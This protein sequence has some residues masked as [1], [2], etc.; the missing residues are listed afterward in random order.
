MHYR[1]LDAYF[2]VASHGDPEAYKILYQE[3]VCKA[4]YVIKSTLRNSLNFPVIPEDFSEYIDY[5]FFKAINEY[6][7]ERGSFSWYV[8]YVV[9]L[10]LEKKVQK[11]I[12]ENQIDYDV[13]DLE[14]DSDLDAIEFLADPCQKTIVEDLAIADFKLKIASPREYHTR[15]D[16]LLNKI[17]LLQYAGYKNAEIARLLGMTINELRSYLKLIQNTKQ[18]VNLK[19]DLK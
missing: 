7:P 14:N 12:A 15:K 11:A 5:L 19:L 17:L 16:K 6:D 13:F 18:V 10:R 3:F 2:H 8:D 9:K 4:K 1:N